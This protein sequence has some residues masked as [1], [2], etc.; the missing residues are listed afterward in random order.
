MKAARSTNLQDSFRITVYEEGF[1]IL[2]V[3]H[4]FKEDAIS[5][6]GSLSEVRGA[7]VKV[8]TLR[9]S[10]TIKTLKGRYAR[11]IST[12]DRRSE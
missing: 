6:L 5:V 12:N 1:G 9:T 8:T 4:R 11:F 3:P 7:R 10:G 2:K